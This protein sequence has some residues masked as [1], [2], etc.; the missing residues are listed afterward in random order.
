L[1]YIGCGKTRLSGETGGKLLSG[2]K[3]AAEKGQMT[4]EFFRKLPAGAKAHIDF[5]LL[6]ARLKSCPFKTMSFF[7]ACK[8]LIDSAGF[9]RGLKPPPPSGSS[10]SAA[11]E[12]VPFQNDEFFRSL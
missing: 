12:A 8:A 1:D 4:G 9:M 6:T 7:A 11:C 10:F 3:Q 5:R 2:A